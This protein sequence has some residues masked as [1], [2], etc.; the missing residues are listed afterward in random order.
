[1]RE[2]LNDQHFSTCNIIGLTTISFFFLKI[3]NFF[4][5]F[6]LIFVVKKSF[7]SNIYNNQDKYYTTGVE[8]AN[9]KTIGELEKDNQF[10]MLFMKLIFFYFY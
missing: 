10:V 4:F 6:F 5:T 2:L 8:E 1:M 9:G 3:N 7:S